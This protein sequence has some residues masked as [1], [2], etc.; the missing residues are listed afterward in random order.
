MEV[1]WLFRV[2]PIHLPF[3]FPKYLCGQLHVLS[4]CILDQGSINLLA[5]IFRSVK[6]HD[7][8]DSS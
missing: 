4:T 5:T 8:Q 1:M 3:H 6:L 2:L 7:L